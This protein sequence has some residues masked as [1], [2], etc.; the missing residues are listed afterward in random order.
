MPSSDRPLCFLFDN[1]SLRAAATLSLRGIAVRLSSAIGVEVRPV[2]LLHSSGVDASELG[3]TPAELLEPSLLAYGRSGGRSAV[4]LPL[5]FGPSGALTEYLPARLAS[6]RRHCPELRVTCASWLV[7]PDDDSENI[8]AEMLADAVRRVMPAGLEEPR[9]MLVDHGSPQPAVTA[10]RDRLGAALRRALAGEHATVGVASMERRGGDA[11]AFNEPLL[12]RAL[13]QPPFNTGDV[14]IALQ[15][16]QAGRHAGAGGD[17]A[18]IC[19]EAEREQP[20]LRTHLTEPL[21]GDARLLDILAQR[22]RE[23][24]AAEAPDGNG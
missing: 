7:R 13:R 21:G 24:V 20:G 19:S 5:F 3:G 17:I 16:L 15:F 22:Y 2:S 1:G 18:A 8:M 10:V 12:E 6:V 4:L 14:I 9:V 23:A 11:Y